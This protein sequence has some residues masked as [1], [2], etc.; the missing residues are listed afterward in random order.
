MKTVADLNALIPKLRELMLQHDDR[1]TIDSFEFEC[2]CIEYEEDGWDILVEYQ[3]TADWDYNRHD[4]KCI[5]GEVTS[6]FAYHYDETTNEEIE[7]TEDDV[8]EVW[9]ALNKLIEKK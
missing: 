1:Y 2:N 8:V 9:V 3:L 6:L 5:Y 7:F 4:A